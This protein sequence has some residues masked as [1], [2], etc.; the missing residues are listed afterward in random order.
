MSQVRNSDLNDNKTIVLAYLRKEYLF[1]DKDF[2]S[3]LH[4]WK[5]KTFI[6]KFT[7]YN[8]SLV[9]VAKYQHRIAMHV[10]LTHLQQNFCY[11]S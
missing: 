5:G 6:Q 10:R 8:V 1:F 7:K 3:Y 4:W 11:T 2:S 9:N